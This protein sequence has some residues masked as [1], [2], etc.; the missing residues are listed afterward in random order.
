MSQS[1]L[2]N[3][4]A[5]Y[6]KPDPTRVIVRP[7]KPSSEPQHLN[8][9]NKSRASKIV[10]RVLSLDPPST[11]NQLRDILAK[12]DG[13]H[14]NL[15]RQFELR[16]DAMEDAFAHHKKFSQQQRQLV[17]AYFLNE[18]SFESAALF[19]PSVV[20]HPDQS[21]VTAGSRRLIL[22]LRAVGEGHISSLTFRSGV[23][24]ADGAVAID[25]P[26]RLASLPSA[27]AG[28]G[29]AVA[30]R[31]GLSFKEESDLSER[32]IFP[33]TEAQSNGIEDARFVAFEDEGKTTYFATY[34]AYSGSSIRSE[35]L[36]TT[37]FLNFTMTPLRGAAARNKGMALFPRRINGRYA[38]V[39]RQDSENLYLLYSDDLHHWDEGRLLMKPEFAW[40][41]VQIGN[42]GSPIEIDEGWLLF[43]HGV[44]PMRRYAIGVTLLD[45]HDPSIILSRTVEPLLQPE[46]T[47]REGYVPNVV[48]S[49]GA[50]RHGDLIALPYAVSDTYSN[51]TTIKIGRLL[52]TM[53]P[54]GTAL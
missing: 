54:I 28:D 52:D 29:P 38:M 44:G 13:R 16:A 11:A 48:Y 31:I 21:G 3:R 33:V 1:S 37:D 20:P 8:P 12:F 9:Q 5:L 23:I 19:N 36:E 53:H 35:L 46:P 26:A 7:F 15:L 30:G 22:S 34:T 49:C 39:A 43:T 41:F 4:Q 50:M 47:E 6:L 51:F 27:R 32:V 40:Q 10:D 24:D 14:R 25:A 18:Y 42:C 2:V 45:K 17:G